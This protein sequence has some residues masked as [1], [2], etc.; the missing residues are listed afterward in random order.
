M[1][2]TIERHLINNLRFHLV[3]FILGEDNLDLPN[4]ASKQDPRFSSMY[5]TIEGH[6]VNNLRFHLV[7]FI[8]GEDN[9]D[10]PNNASKQD[11]RTLPRQY[12]SLRP[13]DTRALLTI[14]AL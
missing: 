5:Y 11:P 3:L 7:V 9:L 12:T 6:L 14:S 8:M 1:Y 10:L 4:N 2:Y 13:K